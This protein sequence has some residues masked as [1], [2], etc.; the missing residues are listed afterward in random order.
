[1]A[2]HIPPKLY[3]Y[4]SLATPYTRENLQKRQIWFSKPESLNDPFDCAVPFRLLKIGEK[5]W[6]I[7]Y[8][9]LQKRIEKDL[10]ADKVKEAD[11]QFLTN[12]T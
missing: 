4:Q 9:N 5:E 2:K 3:K 12:G 10:G 8:R 6:E 7:G 11:N 1:M